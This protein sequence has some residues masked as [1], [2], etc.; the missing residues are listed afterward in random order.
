M[1]TR[2]PQGSITEKL[3]FWSEQNLPLALG[4]VR[5]FLSALKIRILH[6]SVCSLRVNRA[7]FVN[8]LAQRP[9][10]GKADLP[11]ALLM[12]WEE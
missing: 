7:V 12:K 8:H 10:L 4:K 11:K 1:D 2:D 5:V 9:S 6:T 3:S